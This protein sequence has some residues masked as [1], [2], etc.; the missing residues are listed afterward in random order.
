MVATQP[1]DPNSVTAEGLTRSKVVPA[2]W[3]VTK[4]MNLPVVAVTEYANGVVIRVEGNRCIFQQNIN[5]DFRDYYD[6]FDAAQ[7]YAEASRVITYEAL[8][9]N[10]NLQVKMVAPNEWLL[11]KLSSNSGLAPGFQA[12]SIRLTKRQARAIC[13]L[14]FTGER[15]AIG[16]E[17]N[18]HIALGNRMPEDDLKGWKGL[19]A[20]LKNEILPKIEG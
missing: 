14:N 4:R 1:L 12:T 9:I 7:K 5:G 15:E 16:L 3:Q 18:Y 13:N 6:A 2:D 17:C 20:I 8:G 19:Q 11:A 10:W